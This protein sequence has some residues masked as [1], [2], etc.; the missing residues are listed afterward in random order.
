MNAFELWMES[1]DPVKV[2]A[3]ESFHSEQ[4]RMAMALHEAEKVRF[5]AS[6]SR[7]A[8]HDAFLKRIAE[9]WEFRGSRDDTPKIQPVD[10]SLSKRSDR[11]SVK[12]SHEFTAEQLR[13]S[14]AVLEK[15]KSDGKDS[16]HSIR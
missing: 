14:Q 11:N 5:M 15:R 1:L 7:L 13:I 4:H 9:H 10:D 3:T 2:A 6:R 16:V 8:E 12:K